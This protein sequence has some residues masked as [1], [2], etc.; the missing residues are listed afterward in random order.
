VPALRRL[1]RPPRL[2][3]RPQ[4]FRKD[5]DVWIMDRILSTQAR[6]LAILLFR[7]RGEGGQTMAEYGIL[8]AVIAIVVV[9]AAVLLGGN[10][11]E[12]FR[13]SSTHL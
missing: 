7:L 2:R 3:S 8:I 10:I 11:S 5:A 4:G 1:T 13:S 9:V 12:L 6:Y